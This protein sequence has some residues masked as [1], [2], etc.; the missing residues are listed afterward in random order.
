MNAS[1]GGRHTKEMN[2]MAFWEQIFESF[3]S[4]T[5]ERLQK[6]H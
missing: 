4:D 1:H 6:L 5:V 2:L 3:V